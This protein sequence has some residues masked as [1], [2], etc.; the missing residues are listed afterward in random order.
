MTL[1]S[2]INHIVCRNY[3]HHSEKCSAAIFATGGQHGRPTSKFGSED[4]L[5]HN[6]YVAQLF[7]DLNISY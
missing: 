5:P 1:F 7:V 6:F 2:T 3:L 4:R